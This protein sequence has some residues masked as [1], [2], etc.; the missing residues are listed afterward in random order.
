M[1]IVVVY[2]IYSLAFFTMGLALFIYP[3]QWSE[4]G[5]SMDLS[6]IAAFGIAHGINEWL[7]MYLL[8]RDSLAATYLKLII[9]PLSYLFLFHFGVKTCVRLKEWP[10][11]LEMLTLAPIVIWLGATFASED[12]FLTGDVLG[13]Y[14]VGIPGIFL[15]AYA[16]TL[17]LSEIRKKGYPG[18]DRFLEIAAASFLFYGIFSGFIV[19]Q[20]D[21]FPANIINL[22]EFYSVT[23]IPVQ[24]FRALCAVG[25]ALGMMKTLSVFEWETRSELERE[26]EERKQAEEALKR[27]AEKLEHSNR[28]KNL[29]TDIM[30]HDLMNPIS[31][32]KGYLYLIKS[33]RAGEEIINRVEYNIQKAANMIQKAYVLAKLEDTSQLEKTW[34]DLNSLFSRVIEDLDSV[35]KSKNIS[36]SYL[37][38]GEYS[39]MANSM[40]EEV[41]SNLITNAVKYGP[42]NSEITVDIESE[43][44]LWVV[45]V[46]DRGVGIPDEHKETIFQ[47]FKKVEKQGIKGTGLGLAIV[48]RIVELHRGKVWVEDNPDGGSVFCVALPKQGEAL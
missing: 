19:P 13:R 5:F 27:Y 21:Y 20:A 3:K 32:A 45:K 46:Y 37:P 22:E 28:L 44:G 18:V 25:A 39:V 26:V 47:R 40:I 12:I 17:H 8:I 30:R 34:L 11:S 7:D 2:F 1:D 33:G 6:L 38:E 48:K 4:L 10:K 16:L 35:I 23:G 9:L 36:V 42:E 31:G 43:E 15:T 14:L 24:V 41:F 29:F